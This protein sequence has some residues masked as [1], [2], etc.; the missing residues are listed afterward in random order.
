M[1][2]KEVEIIR[3]I[4]AKRVELEAQG[5]KLDMSFIRKVTKDVTDFDAKLKE[6]K[7][8]DEQYKALLK[9]RLQL[10]ADRKKN[11]DWEILN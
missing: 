1:E 2:S 5:I 7:Q 11:L 9:D 6:L 4:E 3:K 8:K 10:L